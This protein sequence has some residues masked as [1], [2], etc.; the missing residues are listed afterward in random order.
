MKK[1]ILLLLILLTFSCVDIVYAENI[2]RY[3]ESVNLVPKSETS[4]F[5]V[6]EN[7][8][9]TMYYNDVLIN[10]ENET[11]KYLDN[12]GYMIRPGEDAGT[13][14]SEIIVNNETVSEYMAKN[15]HVCQNISYSIDDFL[16]QTE[17]QRTEED[18]RAFWDCYRNLLLKYWEH[19]NPPSNLYSYVPAE[20][21][22]PGIALTGGS[23]TNNVY[24]P[25]TP[26][27]LIT[28]IECQSLI[29]KELWYPIVLDEVLS[30]YKDNANGQNI[31]FN[32]LSKNG[33]KYNN[34]TI[35]N[36]GNVDEEGR[37]VSLEKLRITKK[38]YDAIMNGDQKLKLYIYQSHSP[39]GMDYVEILSDGKYKPAFIPTH[40]FDENDNEVPLKSPSKS[41]HKYF[42]TIE[43]DKSVIKD[44]AIYGLYLMQT[45]S[46]N[47]NLNYRMGKY[48]SKGIIYYYRFKIE[49]EIVGDENVKTAV[50]NKTNSDKDIRD[51]NAKIYLDDKV[52]NVPNKKSFSEGRIYV[53]LNTLCKEVNCSYKYNKNKKTYYV[54]YY[55]I[56]NNESVVYSLVL[57]ENSNVFESVLKVYDE[58]YE[59]KNKILDASPFV[60]HDNN[61]YVPIRFLLE[62]LGA[63]IDYFP[64]NGEQPEEVHLY[65]NSDKFIDT[66]NGNTILKS[67]YLPVLEQ[68]TEIVFKQKYNMNDDS[69]DMKNIK[70][71]FSKNNLNV[72]GYNSNNKCDITIKGS[73]VRFNSIKNISN[74]KLYIVNTYNNYPY[75]KEIHLI[76]E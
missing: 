5:K 46:S 31:H 74:T 14:L 20:L 15:E 3:G 4:T 69:Y 68:S 24:C 35:T 12:V 50:T 28:S 11:I 19:P 10:L 40:A 7:Y 47:E 58:V 75:V 8:Q 17:V 25:E 18:E 27:P 49:L 45:G 60:D 34:S 2:D 37:Y 33:S 56:N 43:L 67:K 29:N 32:Y 26:I 61:L 64:T 55:P 57:K 73:T 52:I 63:Q 44:N 48:N 51:N 22:A 9:D 41:Y 70:F 21:S 16:S 36:N 23:K 72:C 54:N 59:F 76:T 71:F 42:N 30:I 65:L 39:F 38:E 66:Y 13:S 6:G 1:N 53:E 62:G